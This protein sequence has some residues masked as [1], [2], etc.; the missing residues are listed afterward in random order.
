M[1]IIDPF[2]MKSGL[3]AEMKWW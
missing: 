3:S 2:T 1:H